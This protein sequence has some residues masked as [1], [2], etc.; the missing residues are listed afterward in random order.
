MVEVPLAVFLPQMHLHGGGQGHEIE[1]CAAA[2]GTAHRDVYVLD[3]GRY[4]VQ[5]RNKQAFVRQDDGIVFILDDRWDEFCLSYRRRHA[6]H[7]HFRQRQSFF[8]DGEGLAELLQV[9]GHEE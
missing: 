4:G 3:F 1:E 6:Y 9:S 5:H 8:V 7:L 2:H